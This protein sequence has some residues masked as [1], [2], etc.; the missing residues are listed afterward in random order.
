MTEK[1][2]ILTLQYRFDGAEQVLF[3][4]LLFGAEDLVLVDCGY[5]GSLEQLEAQLR[6]CHVEPSDLTH[7]VLTHQDDDH[8]GA[9]AEWK[10]KY[11]STQILA[12][13][14]EEPYISGRRKNLRLAQAEA[15]QPQL[16]EDSRA[17]GEAFCDRLRRLRPVPVDRV[18]RAGE[19]F[20][21]GG[22]CEILPTPGHTPGHISLRSLHGDF[23]I[24]GDA[25]V[26]EG[27]ALVLANPAF[28]LDPAAAERSLALVR[29]SCTRAYICYHG[30]LLEPLSSG[31]AE[32]DF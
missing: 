3:P 32:E 25:A 13:C 10:E 27:D 21:W 31:G 24:T 1:W 28:C 12:S 22:G 23:L 26:R 9:A 17:W 18:L 8:M 14:E 19:T 4:A 6:A 16:P 7:L 15:L 30:G 29:R 11:P 20:D 2:K 5:P